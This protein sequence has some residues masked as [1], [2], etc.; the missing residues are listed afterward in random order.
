M[1]VEGSGRQP[2]TPN[3]RTAELVERLAELN[4]D[5]LAGLAAIA[6]DPKTSV[7]LRADIHKTLL[8]YVF[9]KRRSVDVTSGE[10]PIVIHFDAVDQL[11]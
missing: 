10:Q 5:P 2:G 3:K 8:N 11:L 9:P 6:N 4:L 1:R 7:E